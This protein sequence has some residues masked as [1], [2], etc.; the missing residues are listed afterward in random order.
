[1]SL[2]SELDRWGWARGF[3]WVL[4]YGVGRSESCGQMG[5]L[6]GCPKWM[7]LMPLLLLVVSLCGVQRVRGRLGARVGMDELGPGV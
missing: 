5:D 7:T 4:E 1:M 3:G 6:P 2:V